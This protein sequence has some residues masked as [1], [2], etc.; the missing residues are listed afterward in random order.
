MTVKTTSIDA[1]IA[2]RMKDS[3]FKAGFEEESEKLEATLR[4]KIN[5]E[6]TG[7]V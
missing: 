2:E 3:E 7:L 4:L 5:Q 6:D 1:Y